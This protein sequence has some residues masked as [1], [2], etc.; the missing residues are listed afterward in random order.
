MHTT[1]TTLSKLLLING[2]KRGDLAAAL[3]VSHQRVSDLCTGR[4]KLTETMADRIELV[5]NGMIRS[6]RLVP[7]CT[8]CG[9]RRKPSTLTD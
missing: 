5:T 9:A 8:H 7:K 2:M 1:R 6:R 4:S 3:G